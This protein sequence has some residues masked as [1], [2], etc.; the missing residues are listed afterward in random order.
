MG[1][2]AWGD[3]NA[4]MIRLLSLL[5]G[6]SSPSACLVLCQGQEWALLNQQFGLSLGG[7]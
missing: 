5:P 2:G 1:E 4:S 3:L 7:H 6:K